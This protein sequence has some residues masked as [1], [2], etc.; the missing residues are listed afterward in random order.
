M[1]KIHEHTKGK[2]L[3]IR[4]ISAALMLL[5]V[6][7]AVMKLIERDKFTAELGKSPLLADYARE[8]PYLVP[9]TELL[10]VLL[11]AVPATNLAGLYASVWLLTFFTVYLVAILNYS[12]YIPC[13]C[14]GILSE[15]SWQAHILFN[16][17]F[18]LLAVTAICLYPPV[19]NQEG[20]AYVKQ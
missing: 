4:V 8:L 20:G 10:I 17:C 16:A 3:L 11:L 6:Y 19:E 1:K 15:L 14:G 12:Y 18:I 7:P 13:A 9:G 5:W 2:T